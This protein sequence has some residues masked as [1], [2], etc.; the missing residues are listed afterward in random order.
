MVTLGKQN[1]LETRGSHHLEEISSGKMNIMADLEKV[2]R[3]TYFEI[4]SKITDF[5]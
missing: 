1:I 2:Q 4:S 3:P 5:H